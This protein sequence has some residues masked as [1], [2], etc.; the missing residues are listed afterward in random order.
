MLAKTLASHSCS[1][2][3]GE[4][5]PL[6]GAI[7]SGESQ[8]DTSALTG[9]PVPRMAHPGHEIFAGLINKTATLTVRVSKTYSDSSIAKILHL[10]ENA[11]TYKSKT[12]N[13]ITRFS[14]VYT[15]IVVGMALLVALLPPLLF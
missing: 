5:V 10:V 13:F 11:A 2:K 15:P 3:P 8:V 9:E 7:I 6:D 12:E 1:V 4:K 14:R